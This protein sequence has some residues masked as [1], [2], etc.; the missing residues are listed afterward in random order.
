MEY[1]LYQEKQTSRGFV[2]VMTIL[3]IVGGLSLISYTKIL[4]SILG[5]TPTFVYVIY[6]IAFFFIVLGILS[7][8]WV[9]AL[10]RRSMGYFSERK[11]LHFYLLVGL[12]I[13]SFFFLGL[14][15][16]LTFG[17]S[18]FYVAREIRKTNDKKGKI[19]MGI[20]AV[21]IGISVI[22]LI[23]YLFIGM[24]IIIETVGILM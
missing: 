13:A 16:T 11:D 1:S 23:L 8:K 10:R 22:L 18:A 2:I 9:P 21:L 17:I 12:Y 4:T 6:G 15:F 24:K 14:L 3:L 5:E 19:F 20:S 7:F